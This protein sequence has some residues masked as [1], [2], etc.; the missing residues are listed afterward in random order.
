M[1][2]DNEMFVISHFYLCIPITN[3]NFSSHNMNKLIVYE[4]ICEYAKNI[5]YN[6]ST[7]ERNNN[8]LDQKLI[9]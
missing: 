3:V 1:T 8:V 5:S 9:S 4:N 7:K 6:V 2:S